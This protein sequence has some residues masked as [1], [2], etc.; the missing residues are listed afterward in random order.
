MQS[1]IAKNYIIGNAK[2]IA[3]PIY[4][5]SFWVMFVMVLGLL[6]S[7]VMGL[8][9]G[10]IE[11]TMQDVWLVL[12][13]HVDANNASETIY[14]IRLPRVVASMC[15][16]ALMALSGYMLQ[17]LSR[18]PLVDPSILGLTN[19]ATMAA[20]LLYFMVPTLPPAYAS[21]STAIG[22]I[23]TGLFILFL[24][25]GHM[26]GKF[27]LLVGI[28]VGTVFSAITDVLLAS[29][30]MERMVTVQIMLAG[31]FASITFASMNLLLVMV[32]ICGGLF[33]AFSRSVNPMSLGYQVAERLGV[34]A[35]T[36]RLA[37][38]GLAIMA[39]A[40][41]VALAG[42]ISFIG[43]IATFFAKNIIGYRGS[44]LGTVS[45]LFGAI[46]TTWA[47]TLGRTLFAPIMVHAGVFVGVI[48]ALFFV[49]IIRY[50]AVNKKNS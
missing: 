29:L 33:F 10:S 48:G 32:V 23:V 26:Q 30:D 35:K 40:P 18:N 36:F 49:L 25:R 19:G 21:L 6:F 11:V 2:N 31:S 4:K 41:V 8:K 3:L 17:I 34:C 12:Q 16:G 9:L 15:A 24:A 5:R 45:M 28:A 37:L 50:M 47:D 46:I 7:F 20:I 38:V 43:L 44:E 14:E 22:A 27:I 42:S 13:G 39:M 1:I